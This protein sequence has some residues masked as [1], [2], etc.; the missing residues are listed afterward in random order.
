MSHKSDDDDDDD[1]FF[2]EDS[3]GGKHCVRYPT[4]VRDKVRFV[5]EL[6]VNG[7]RER[8]AFSAVP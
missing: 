8:I 3:D 4:H 5:R 7:A 6:R 1:G 2:V